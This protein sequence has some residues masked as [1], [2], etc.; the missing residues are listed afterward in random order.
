MK[1]LQLIRDVETRWSFVYLMIDRV[2]ILKEVCF[3]LTLYLSMLKLS[4]AITKFLEEQ[5]EVDELTD[6][7]WET[8]SL[9]K[10]IL[11][12]FLNFLSYSYLL[13]FGL[14]SIHLSGGPML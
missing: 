8:L 7:D 10:Q 12:V 1:P 11:Q 4:Q 3:K 14:D 9:M 5:G 2:I 6:E 13:T